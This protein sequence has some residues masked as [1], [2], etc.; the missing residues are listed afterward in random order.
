M[1]ISKHTQDI[2][3]VILP[4]VTTAYFKQADGF[5]EWI[6]ALS[7]IRQSKLYKNSTPE[8]RVEMITKLDYRPQHLTLASNEN[9]GVVV[10][11]AYREARNRLMKIKPKV[12]ELLRK[13]FTEI[14]DVTLSK[15]NDPGME[16]E[17]II[18]SQDGQRCKLTSKTSF[19]SNPRYKD[20]V[21]TK[22]RVEK[23]Q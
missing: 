5:V 2:S 13:H 3:T 21:R 10:E 17:W 4:G 12:E 9:K 8:K 14:K 1:T 6:E 11:Y 7:K 15:K 18:T 23:I 20:I 22:M 19:D 16:Y